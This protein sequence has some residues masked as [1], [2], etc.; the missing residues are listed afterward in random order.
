MPGRHVYRLPGR[1][2]VIHTILLLTTMLLYTGRPRF[3]VR[4][5]DRLVRSNPLLR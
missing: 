4:D 5:S 3:F 2:M 1:R